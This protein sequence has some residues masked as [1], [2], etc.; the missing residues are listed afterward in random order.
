[1][2]IPVPG[3]FVLHTFKGPVTKDLTA[4]DPDGNSVNLGKFG[5]ETMWVLVADV[6]NGQVSGRLASNPLAVDLKSD[7]YVSFPITK[8]E[9]LKP[10]K[11][12]AKF[13]YRGL[14]FLSPGWER[15]RETV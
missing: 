4:R 9:G 3:D 12:W 2:K 8:I 15:G 1:M 6:K 10:G 7:Q 14:R 11:T 5:G 13:F